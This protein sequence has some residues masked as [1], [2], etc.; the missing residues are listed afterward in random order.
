MTVAEMKEMLSQKVIHFVDS[1]GDEISSN[2]PE[3]KKTSNNILRF[4]R[5][6][7]RLAYDKYSND[8]SSTN[9]EKTPVKSPAKPATKPSSKPKTSSKKVS[10]SK[11]R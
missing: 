8:M 9:V 11:K 6:A 3:N 1:L 2:L 4:K 7:C 10:K 5:L